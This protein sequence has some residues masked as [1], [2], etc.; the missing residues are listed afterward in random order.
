MNVQVASRVAERLNTEDLRKLGN[1][2]NIPEMLG[3]DGKYPAVYPK[4]KFWICLQSF[5][6]DCLRKQIFISNSVQVPLVLY[7]LKILVFEKA[8]L[9]F[10][11]IFK[12]TQLENVPEYDTFQKTVFCTL[13]SNMNL[14]LNAVPVAAGKYL[15]R[16]FTFIY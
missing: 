12:A 15:R 16:D 3:F 10:K 5:V 11:L 4:V 6:Q 8:H 13:V 9:L 1:F 2:K 14:G 7:F